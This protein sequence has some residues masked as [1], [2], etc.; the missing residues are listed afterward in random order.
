MAERL[1]WLATHT[2]SSSPSYT[3]AQGGGGGG[4]G[5]AGGV[6][7]AQPHAATAAGET[8]QLPGQRAPQNKGGKCFPPLAFPA[9]PCTLNELLAPQLCVTDLKLSQPLLETLRLRSW[10]P[11]GVS[12]PVI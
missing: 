9:P 10:W 11:S 8:R 4:G 2:H 1:T 7:R 6:D 5:G 12:S 3:R